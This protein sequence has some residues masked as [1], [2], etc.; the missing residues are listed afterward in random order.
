MGQ[1]EVL[2]RF[3]EIN[4]QDLEHK[5]FHS[6]EDCPNAFYFYEITTFQPDGKYLL[7][8]S[9]Q[10]ADEH[11]GT[12]SSLFTI[13]YFFPNPQNTQKQIEYEATEKTLEF[14]T[15]A[16]EAFVT[17]DKNFLKDHFEQPALQQKSNGCFSKSISGAF[18]VVAAIAY[19]LFRII[20]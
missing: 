5:I 18:V 3:A 13:N 2:R 12:G 20:Y 8:I 17:N 16:L 1:E 9:P 19:I 11:S 7:N 4:W 10:I 14:C 6:G 15:K